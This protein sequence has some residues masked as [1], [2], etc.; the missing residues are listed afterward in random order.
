MAQRIEKTIMSN[1]RNKPAFVWSL[2]IYSGLFVILIY[3]LHHLKLSRVVLA[4]SQLASFPTK[5]FLSPGILGDSGSLAGTSSLGGQL[6]SKLLG[7]SYQLIW[8]YF[9]SY[10]INYH[11]CGITF[12]DKSIENSRHS[13]AWVTVLVFV[14]CCTCWSNIE[15]WDLDISRIYYIVNNLCPQLGNT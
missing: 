6:P 9:A 3:L 11:T 15:F 10:A 1:G 2:E 5:I 4:T 14:S 8:R 7:L 13:R 12:L